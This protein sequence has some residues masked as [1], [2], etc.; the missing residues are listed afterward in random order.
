MVKIDE[1]GPMKDAL[2]RLAAA[3]DAA[4]DIHQRIGS[5]YALV[6]STES[7]RATGGPTPEH[8]KTVRQE[9]VDL[10]NHADQVVGLLFQAY[11]RQHQ[12]AMA[13]MEEIQAQAM[14]MQRAL[15]FAGRGEPS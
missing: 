1:F 14:G 8:Y 10:A 12:A 3:K 2:A 7:A 9:L 6:D 5:L 13:K 11:Q 15:G 4:L